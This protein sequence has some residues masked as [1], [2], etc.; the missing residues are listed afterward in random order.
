MSTKTKTADAVV[1]LL[2]I[3]QV[4]AAL[5]CCTKTVRRLIEKKELAVVKCGRF[6]RVRQDDLESF[7]ARW[8]RG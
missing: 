5:T 4:A 8:R 6:V 2:T 3:K 1:P 7:I